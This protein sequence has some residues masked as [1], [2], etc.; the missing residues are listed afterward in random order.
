MPYKFTPE[1]SIL[2]SIRKELDPVKELASSAEKLAKSSEER[3]QIAE[4]LPILPKASLS[5]PRLMPKLPK[6]SHLLLSKKL[7]KPTSKA[8]SLLLFL[9][10]LLLWKFAIGS[11]YSKMIPERTNKKFNIANTRAT[12]ETVIFDGFFSFLSFF[13]LP[14]PSHLSGISRFLIL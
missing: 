13:I 12:S 1:Y 3:S 2:S 5:H 7:R 14:L 9:F 10:L 6:R 8:G 11:A 4:R